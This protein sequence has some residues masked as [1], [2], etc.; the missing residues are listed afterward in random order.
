MGQKT[1]PK[2]FRLW[3]VENWDS[4]WFA[5]KRKY[6]DYVMEDF[7]IREFLFKELKNAQPEKIEIKRRLGEVRVNA[8][9]V[10]MGMAIGR[11][12]E[13][14]LRLIAELQKMVD[15]DQQVSLEFYEVTKPDLSAQV[16][17]Q[18]IAQ[19]IERRINFR[20][21]LKQALKRVVQELEA[22]QKSDKVTGVGVRIQVKGRLNGAE[23]RRKEW[24][25]W[26][27]VPLQTLRAK[28]DYAQ[29]TAYCSYGTIGVKVWI[30]TGDEVKEKEGQ[31]VG[32]VS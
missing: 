13:N 19:Q 22:L 18:N 10:R 4:V 23:M 15:P 5:P 16:V 29:A 17:A 12:G 9:V 11:G 14:K 2:G 3:T 6:P 8:H 30:Y 28:I 27:R 20:R 32:E 1:H 7:R 25:H 24:Y 26:G 21:V 31:A